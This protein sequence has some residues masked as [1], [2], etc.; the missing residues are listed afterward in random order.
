MSEPAIGQRRTWGALVLSRLLAD[1]LVVIVLI[2]WWLMSQRLPQIVLPDP[3]SVA[4]ALAMLFHDPD[5]LRHV[6]ATGLRVVGSV[7]LA[8]LLAAALA[9]LAYYVALL[10]D[11]VL[12]RIQPFLGAM[13]SVGWAIIGLIWFKVSD[14]TVVFIQV[15]ILIPFCLINFTQGLRDLDAE[16][17]E[18][19]RS[20]TRSRW[21]VLSK[22][23]VPL[24]LPHAVAALRIAYGVCWKIALVSELFGAE[25]GLGYVMLQAQ[26]LSDVTTVIATCLA[27]VLLFGA[28][29][30]LV[31]RPLS[32]MVAR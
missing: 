6:A 11:V 3:W 16:L 7:V 20:F 2:A 8:T 22:L 29:D 26:I 12:T 21:L 25:T 10:Q 4:Q 19:G 14:F 31:L 30:Y 23:V 32:K 1:G 28:G 15:A 27:I 9:G 5:S 17:I 24:L 13:P 18:M